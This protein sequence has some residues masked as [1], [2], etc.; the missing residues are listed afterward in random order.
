[1]REVWP[2]NLLLTARFGL[3]EFDR[4]DEKTL[5]ES[6]DFVKKFKAGGLDVLNMRIDFLTP[7]SLA[8]ALKRASESGG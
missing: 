8:S 3:I 4:S 6:N 1:V 5:A 7:Y 2:E